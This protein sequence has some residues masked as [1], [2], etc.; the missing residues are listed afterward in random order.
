MKLIDAVLLFQSG[1]F[2]LFGL[3]H[4]LT[5][6]GNMAGM[7]FDYAKFMPMKGKAPLPVPEEINLLIFHI[8]AILGSAQLSLVLMGLMAALTTASL[9]PKKLAVRTFMAYNVLITI[10][11]FYKPSGTGKEGSPPTGPLP[12]IVGLAL[13]A[14][15]AS[16]AY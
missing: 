13:P 11:Q 14:A 8:A 10:M 3:P 12:V 2:L 6:D 4:V 7:G 1:V 15:Y 5:E 9:E 16:F